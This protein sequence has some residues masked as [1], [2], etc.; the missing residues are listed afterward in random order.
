MLTVLNS[1]KSSWLR[2][3]VIF[4]SVA[5]M[6]LPQLIDRAAAVA[7]GLAELDVHRK[8]VLVAAASAQ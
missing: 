7:A 3:T 6:S 2:D 4:G 1:Q 8:P 5:L